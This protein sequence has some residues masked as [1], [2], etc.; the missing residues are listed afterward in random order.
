MEGGGAGI[1]GDSW[2]GEEEKDADDSEES[3][4]RSGRFVLRG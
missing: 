2:A 1:L 4:A 3:S